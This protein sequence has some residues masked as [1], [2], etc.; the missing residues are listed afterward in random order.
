MPDPEASTVKWKYVWIAIAVYVALLGGYAWF[1][2]GLSDVSK[3]G[4]FGDAFGAF[5]AA[6]SGLGFIGLAFTIFLQHRQLKMQSE[7]LRLQREELT[8]TRGELQRTAK[9][10]EETEKALRSQLRVMALSSRLSALTLLI[11]EEELHLRHHHE[12]RDIESL[13]TETLGKHLQ[14]AQERL[15]TGRH[16]Q[17]DYCLRTNLLDLIEFRKD[18]KKIYDDLRGI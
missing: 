7:E 10:Q 1:A 15:N 4:L 6:F 9:A 17:G 11:K 13:T 16:L 5:N 12:M 8:L 3:G 14:S 18:L 2:W